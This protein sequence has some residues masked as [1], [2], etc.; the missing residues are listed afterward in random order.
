MYIFITLDVYL[1][2][3]IYAIGITGDTHSRWNGFYNEK[4]KE[5]NPD[6]IH[7]AWQTGSSKKITRLAF[8]LYTNGVATAY[9]D[10]KEDFNECTQYSVSDIFCCSFAPFFVEAIKLRYPEYFTTRK[11]YNETKFMRET[12]SE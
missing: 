3:L 12:M 5:I 2:A 11:V 6:I 9:E 8:Q 10:N 4:L 1:K 7:E